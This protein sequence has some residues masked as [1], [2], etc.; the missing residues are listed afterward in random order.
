MKILLVNKFIYPRGGD[1]ICTLNLRKMLEAA[2]HEVRFFAMHHPLNE[3]Y[4]ENIYFPDEV[5][6]VGGGLLAKMKAAARIIWGTGVRTH[7]EKLLDDFLPDVVHLHNVHSYLSPIV[8]EVAYRK[9][10]RVVWTLHDYKLICP[11]YACLRRGNVCEE[12]FN[13]KHKVLTQKCMKNSWLASLLAYMEAGRW[14]RKKIS[15]WVD[16]FICP[17]QF[18]ADKMKI[19]GFPTEKLSTVCNCIDDFKVKHIRETTFKREKQCY[20]YIG[21]LSEEKGIENLLIAASSLPYTL[22]I[23]G[24]DPQ[25][26]E[27]KAKYRADNIQF[28]G[29][30]TSQNIVKLLQ[31]VRFSVLPSVCYENN[32]LSAIESLCCGTP[33]LGASIGG[34]PELLTDRYCRLFAPGEVEELKKGIV[35]MFQ[36]GDIDNQRLSDRSIERFHP[37]KYL[38]EIETIYQGNCTKA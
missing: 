9:G 11:A 35:A 16:N 14:N 32:P 4:P 33:V 34:I 8:A 23:A 6:F 36:E 15:R 24:D 5:S 10:I 3:V 1:C 18:M 28:V 2:G 7:F 20:C 21:R 25:A 38:K 29:Q 26:S 17:S 12:C 30:L 19:G 31:S 27:L 37:A 22:Y 13:R